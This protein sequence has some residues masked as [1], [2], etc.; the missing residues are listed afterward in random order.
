MLQK[1]FALGSNY[2]PETIWQIYLIN[3]PMVFRAIWSAVK[4]FLH[5][6]TVSHMHTHTHAHTHTHT[7]THTHT[8]TQVNKIQIIGSY[9]EALKKMTAAVSVK[10][11]HTHTNTH[12]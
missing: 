11:T 7:R 1:I 5:P 6:L 10:Y 2:F 9:K 8:Y 12:R 3:S 4:Q